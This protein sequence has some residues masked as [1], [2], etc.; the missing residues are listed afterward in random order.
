[1][2]LEGTWCRGTAHGRVHDRRTGLL[3]V[4]FVVEVSSPACERVAAAVACTKRPLAQQ[5]SRG[6]GARAFVG[7]RAAE[8]VADPRRH[9]E[10]VPDA[11]GRQDCTQVPAAIDRT[12]GVEL[13]IRSW[14]FRRIVTAVTLAQEVVLGLQR[15]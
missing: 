14:F 5:V 10:G 2:W 4:A 9:S 6:S 8:D 3:G 12:E 13:V 1:M 7:Q 11:H 15:P